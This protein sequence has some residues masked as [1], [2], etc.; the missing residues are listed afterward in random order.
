MAHTPLPLGIAAVTALAL[1]QGTAGCDRVDK[2]AAAQTR[3]VAPRGASLEHSTGPDYH[4]MLS[5]IE[6]AYET[7]LLNIENAQTPGYKT[8]RPV[9]DSDS[10]NP[11]LRRDLSHGRPLPTGRWLDLAIDGP[12]YLLVR[13]PERLGLDGLAYSRTGKLHINT[14]GALTLGSADGPAIEP[15]I[16]FPD[17]YGDIRIDAQGRVWV[18]SVDRQDVMEIGQIELARFI[19]EGA[20]CPTRDGLYIATAESGRPTRGRPGDQGFGQTLQKHLE[21][22]NVDIATELAALDQF[23]AWGQSVGESLGI[24]THFDEQPELT[25]VL[26]QPAA[27]PQSTAAVELFGLHQP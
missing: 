2:V 10:M 11:E 16:V 17:E 15:R 4:R 26:P 12:G 14:E 3:Y 25:N 18:V 13:D 5:G 1:L 24:A 6:V 20:L 27:T 23:K 9:F 22:S 8:V 19:N 7:V 21:G